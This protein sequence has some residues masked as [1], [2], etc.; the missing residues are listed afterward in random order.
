MHKQR[1]EFKDPD[2]ICSGSD[3]VSI[4]GTDVLLDPVYLALISIITSVNSW[5][6]L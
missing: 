5:N 1:E 4:Q 6:D 3:Y 2:I